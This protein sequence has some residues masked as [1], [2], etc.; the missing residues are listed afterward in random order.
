MNHLIA[1]IRSAKGKRDQKFKKLLSGQKIYNLDAIKLAAIQDSSVSYQPDHNLDEGT[2][3]CIQQ[4]SQQDYF[5]EWLAE[6]FSS[7]NYQLLAKEDA[8]N[9]QFLCA[10]QD[11]DLYC[12]QRVSKA[13]YFE[14]KKF[15]SLGDQYKFQQDT[16]LLM[17]N[18]QPDAIY[19]KDNDI[20]FFRSLATINAIFNGI[21]QLYKEATDEETRRF[22]DSD[23]IQLD[24]G[25]NVF[26]VSKPN[27]HR[28]AMA[29]E[30]LK[31]LNREEREQLPDYIQEYCPTLARNGDA[32]VVATDNDLKFVLYG[33]EQRYYTTPFT[34]ERCIASAVLKI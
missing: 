13:Q 15:V 32:F 25:F 29:S 30:T 4:F 22:L 33:I 5:L 17:I 24:G 16:P 6:P 2:W 27:R 3:F 10:Y 8:E 34:A 7:A 19:A 31:K 23:F 28:I 18:E 26:K 12:F 9:I 11:E 14:K 1:R 20:L 21:D